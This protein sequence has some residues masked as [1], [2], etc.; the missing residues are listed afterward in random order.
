M[1]TF[2]IVLF[3]IIAIPSLAFAQDSSA[4]KLR[5]IKNQGGKQLTLEELRAL[6]PGA[7]AKRQLSAGHVQYWENSADGKLLA[8]SDNRSVG[9]SGRPTTATG[10]WHIAENGSYCVLIEWRTA[11]EQW[12]KFIFKSGDKYHLFYS[13]TNDAGEAREFEFHR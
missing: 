10:T 13:A 4:L 5:D 7:K 9:G 3:G 11:T 2:L 1:R 6:L 12:C 8:N